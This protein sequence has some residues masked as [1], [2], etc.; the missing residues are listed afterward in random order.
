MAQNSSLI[1][2]LANGVVVRDPA[3]GAAADSNVGPGAATVY[4][5][6]IDNSGNPNQKVYL[7]MWD[8]VAPTVGT[9]APNKIIP[10]PGGSIQK[11]GCIEGIPFTTALSFACVT[12]GGTGGTTAPTNPVIVAISITT[13]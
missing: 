12:T 9:T 10:V 2:V 1:N 6:Q 5:I 3:I 4:L 8:N 11:V 7:K 13:P